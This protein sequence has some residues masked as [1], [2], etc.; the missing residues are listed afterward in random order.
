MEKGRLYLKKLIVLLGLITLGVPAA[1]AQSTNEYDAEFR[2]DQ[3]CADSVV[4]CAAGCW[5]GLLSVGPGLNIPFDFDIRRGWNGS[6]TL[7]FRNADESAEGGKVIQTADSL[8]VPLCQFGNELAF[9]I[10]GDSLVGVLRRK[11]GAGQ[12]L[13]VTAAPN[14]GYRFE[15]NK[16]QPGEIVFCYLTKPY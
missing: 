12:P 13:T 14:S 5:R 3:R 9:R 16:H 4:F 15:R 11:D 7:F 2:Q 10:A 8:I 6:P 1:F